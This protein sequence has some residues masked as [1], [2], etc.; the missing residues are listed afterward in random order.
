MHLVME[1]RLKILL[2]MILTAVTQ[3]GCVGLIAQLLYSSGQDLV[4]AEFDGLKKKRVAVITATDS[5]QYT[6]D[7]AAK[8]VS[9][10]V[11]QI[12]Q[13]KVDGIK[14]VREE[15]VDDWRDNHG[16]DKLNYVAVGRGVK[17]DKVIAIE[18][19]DLRLRDGAT[20]YRGQV[21]V[22]TTVYDVSSG[23]REFRRH[24][25]DYAYPVTGGQYTSETTEA[26]FRRV[27]LHRLSEVIARYFHKYDF[28][29][30][31]ALDADLL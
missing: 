24:L 15:E 21:S 3:T 29:D 23:H 9:R 27:F 2:V 7:I 16:W 12:L 4:P 11:S 13:A 22:T 1:N 19:T 26:R 5:S 17:A 31:V 25:D 20:L 14:L 8:M 30:T 10:E 6:D 18:L 28:R